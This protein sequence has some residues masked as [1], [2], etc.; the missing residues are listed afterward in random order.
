MERQDNKGRNLGRKITLLW[1]LMDILKKLRFHVEVV[2]K[3]KR[4]KSNIKFMVTCSCK[5]IK[6]VAVH[7]VKKHTLKSLFW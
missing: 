2:S 1:I 3:V 6:G 5:K 4:F 7:P